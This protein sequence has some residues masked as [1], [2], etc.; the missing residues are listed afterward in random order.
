MGYEV[1]GIH[2]HLFMYI[3]LRKFLR[4]VESAS[5]KILK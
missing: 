4:Y 1:E 2:V 5:E 3:N